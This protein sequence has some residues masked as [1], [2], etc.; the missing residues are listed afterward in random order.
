MGCP[1]LYCSAISPN[2]NH[3]ISPLLF[4]TQAGVAGASVGS[5]L[6]AAAVGASA[7][8]GLPGEDEDN[9]A[10]GQTHQEGGRLWQERRRLGRLQNHQKGT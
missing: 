1:M 5:A 8:G 9:L 6:A 10:A 3:Q 4:L 2:L 7:D